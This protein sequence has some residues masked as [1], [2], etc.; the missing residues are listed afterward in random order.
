PVVAS[1]AGVDAS[2]GDD[3]RCRG[4]HSGADRRDRHELL[5]RLPWLWWRRRRLGAR[6]LIGELRPDGPSRG[7]AGGL[8]KPARPGDAAVA[9]GAAFGRRAAAVHPLD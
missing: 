6:Y 9:R 4:T 3:C 2:L 7:L 5:L 1:L 8:E